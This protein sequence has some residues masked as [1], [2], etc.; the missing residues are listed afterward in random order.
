MV[1]LV[2]DMVLI[3]NPVDVPD[4]D[5]YNIYR[6]V[7]ATPTLIGQSNKPAYIDKDMPEGFAYVYYVTA[8]DKLGNESAFSLPITKTSPPEFTAPLQPTQL[9]TNRTGSL[10]GVEL[11]WEENVNPFAT[12]IP[13]KDIKGYLV[14]RVSMD[15]P[16]GT[17]VQGELISIQSSNKFV[18]SSIPLSIDTHYK[19]TWVYYIVY[20]YDKY[21][22]YSTGISSAVLP[23]PTASSL[24]GI[25]DY[26]SINLYWELPVP[27]K[28]PV[29]LIY[30]IVFISGTWYRGAYLD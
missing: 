23:I 13:E 30:P 18:D 16:G 27:E 17:I 20:A 26:L 2:Y 11:N 12:P 6:V 14:Y 5:H 10:Q 15:N 8:V 22:N 29:S 9:K 1:T 4:F 24:R 25:V 21:F 3:W 7:G 19:M 28:A